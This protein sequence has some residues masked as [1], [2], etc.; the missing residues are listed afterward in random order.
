MIG[1]A[2]RVWRWR[3]KKPTLLREECTS[4]GWGSSFHQ[5][6]K[7][8]GTQSFR[9]V[10]LCLGHVRP[11]GAMGWQPRPTEPWTWI[12]AQVGPRPSVRYA[13]CACPTT[14]FW[15]HVTRLVSQVHSQKAT[16]LRTN[17]PR[18]PPS[19]DLNKV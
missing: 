4:G 9:N 7:D 10:A 14:V 19:S 3:L 18:V 6:L 1:K 12:P 5:V 2:G 11:S 8:G 13:S 15:K 17:L 16:Y